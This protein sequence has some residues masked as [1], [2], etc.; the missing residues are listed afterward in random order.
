[1]IP[2]IKASRV[3]QSGVS[4]R[5]HPR[6]MR[7]AS[8]KQ[9]LPLADAIG[10][11]GSS[12]APDARFHDTF[13]QAPAAGMI[14]ADAAAYAAGDLVRHDPHVQGY[15]A[16]FADGR[17]EGWEAGHEEGLHDGLQQGRQD[18]NSA[19]QV[20]ADALDALGAAIA[21][22][23]TQRRAAIE[24]GAVEIAF[25]ALLRLIGQCAGDRA[26]VADTVRRVLEQVPDRTLQS[27]RL[28][29]TDH[30]L[31]EQGGHGL[32]LGGALL[33]SDERV[34][35]GGCFIDTDAGSLDGR[36]ETQLSELKTLLVELHQAHEAQP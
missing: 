8:G 22:A 24:A 27:I 17:R 21:E 11:A 28:S 6:L 16:G 32:N 30:A 12:A 13:A 35:V 15:E 26:A 29:P 36:L 9:V 10:Q 2:V 19:A 3:A 23:C 7:A 33:V 1:M 18:A 34:E 25:A 20:Q 14:D 4:L 5:L 31:L